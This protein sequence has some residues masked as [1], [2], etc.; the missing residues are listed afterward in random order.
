MIPLSELGRAERKWENGASAS[1]R[2]GDE[3]QEKGQERVFQPNNARKHR[4]DRQKTSERDRETGMKIVGRTI[5]FT[6]RKESSETPG[7][8]FQ[9]F[10]FEFSFVI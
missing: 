1:K 5:W 10:F 8:P 6:K 4:R 7:A 2:G 9:V 3:R